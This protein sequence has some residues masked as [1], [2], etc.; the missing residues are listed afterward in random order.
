MFWKTTGLGKQNGEGWN[1]CQ[2]G[3]W[4]QGEAPGREQEGHLEG[5]MFCRH[6]AWLWLVVGG[7][8]SVC[9]SLIEIMWNLAG[10]LLGTAVLL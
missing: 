8:T 6:E 9:P 5:R 2:V 10:L 7:L 4:E 1:T 3:S